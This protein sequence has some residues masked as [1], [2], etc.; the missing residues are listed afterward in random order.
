MTNEIVQ[1]KL[2]EFN[3]HPNVAVAGT[4]LMEW[5]RVLLPCQMSLLSGGPAHNLMTYDS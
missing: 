2:I 5:T 3:N 1:Y 4:M